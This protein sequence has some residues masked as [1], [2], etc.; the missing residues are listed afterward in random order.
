VQDGKVRA[1]A[2]CFAG[3]LQ[4]ESEC[5]AEAAK[6]F[7]QAV[8]LDESSQPAKIGLAVSQA[9]L[10]GGDMNAACEAVAAAE[11]AGGAS[12]SGDDLIRLGRAW[13][14]LGQEEKGLPLINKAWSRGAGGDATF[15]L[16]LAIQRKYCTALAKEGADSSTDLLDEAV[17]QYKKCRRDPRALFNTGLL[18][19]ERYHRSL[20]WRSSGKGG[21][22]G[23]QGGESSMP[24][25]NTEMGEM[26]SHSMEDE[27][28]A[29]AQSAGL[30]EPTINDILKALIEEHRLQQERG[31]SFQSD[32]LMQLYHFKSRQL[33]AAGGKPAS[34]STKTDPNLKAAAEAYQ[35]AIRA[36]KGCGSLVHLHLARAQALMG[37]LDSALTAL[38]KI[39]EPKP[40]PAAEMYRALYEKPPSPENPCPK[41]L[42]EAR[43]AVAATV[44]EAVAAGPAIL[45]K[46]PLSSA[47]CHVLNVDLV[48][49]ACAL[50]HALNKDS[51]FA[52]AKA[53]TSGLA[54]LVPKAQA[55]T[56]KG[57]VVF[58]E[59]RL[60]AAQAQQALLVSL[61]GLQETEKAAP[62][63]EA[64]YEVFSDNTRWTIPDIEKLIGVCKVGVEVCPLL[65]AAHARLAAAQFLLVDY[66]PE[67]SKPSAKERR[68]AALESC[69]KGLRASLALEG[70]PSAEAPPP[71]V[72]TPAS[73][74]PLAPAPSTPEPPPASP[75]ARGAGS[76]GGSPTKAVHGPPQLA[77]KPVTAGR[78]SAAKSPAVS[79]P[80]A[81]GR[82]RG[83]AASTARS[84]AAVAG[85]GVA[86]VSKT[87]ASRSP[88]SS[89][90]KA[91][92]GGGKTAAATASSPQARASPGARTPSKTAAASSPKAG[93]SA[94]SKT[95]SPRKVGPP[96]SKKAAAEA[97]TAAD[98]GGSVED[99]GSAPLTLKAVARPPPA[100]PTS[101]KNNPKL[102]QTRI[103]LGKVL[104]ELH[105]SELPAEQREELVV[106][107]H[108][109]ME[110]DPKCVDAYTGIAA[111]LSPTNPLAAIDEMAKYPTNDPPNF[112]DSYIHADIL[113]LYMK[114]GNKDRKVLDAPQLE[115]SLYVAGKVL[116]FPGIEKYVNFL[117]GKG[118][119]GMLRRVYAKINEVP[120]SEMK[121]FF[122]AKGWPADGED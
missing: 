119:W 94:A 25:S 122:K 15:H 91:A 103:E 21:Q 33:L 96:A 117:D 68:K 58:Q 27:I 80:T 116:G 52:A 82:G 19:E 37:K 93:V 50:A 78:G 17:Q 120:E 92:A 36:E 64:T 30:F 75:Q 100:A 85:R 57:T 20:M 88:A 77:A 59:L 42:V 22:E 9:L 38:K 79:S 45:S 121:D 83:V 101:V 97:Q 87:A 6:L 18:L 105:L 14:D 34:Q 99:V 63:Y 104:R 115:T 72:A 10:P 28:A 89:S 48:R 56:S 95:A 49:A 39:S 66:D 55:V 47:I 86:A 67:M 113:Q 98:A 35:E 51:N 54:E 8:G 12:L 70:K 118:R 69:E 109:V 81:A 2:L 106:M 84:G 53:L 1:S 112:D 13:L 43:E 108:E 62:L 60:A 29:I 5:W 7:E 61:A 73:P 16:G 110:M 4:Q 32:Y 102:A 3:E 76:Q 11:E 44:E 111:V 40:H 90:P 46:G 74:P 26:S 31:N 41:P 114:V 65:A 23:I 71:S 24:F 107:Y